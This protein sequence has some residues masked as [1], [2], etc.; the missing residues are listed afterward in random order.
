MLARGEA[1]PCASPMVKFSDSLVLVEDVARCIDDLAGRG[2]LRPAMPDQG[3]VVAIG[4]EAYL[5]AVRLVGDAEAGLT[6]QGTDL[7]LAVA[8]DRKKQMR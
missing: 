4:N 7:F 3:G 6:R 5:H 2:Q 8:A 1:G